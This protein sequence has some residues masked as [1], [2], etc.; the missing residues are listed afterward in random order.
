MTSLPEP[1]SFGGG[2]G[3]SS[4]SSGRFRFRSCALEEGV[5]A[6]GGRADEDPAGRFA[7]EFRVAAEEYSLLKMLKDEASDMVSRGC[8]S[9]K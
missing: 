6:R 8:D 5:D 9:A 4:F 7:P 3:A 2:N 1:V